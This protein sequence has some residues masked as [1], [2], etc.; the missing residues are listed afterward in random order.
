MKCPIYISIP[1]ALFF[2][3]AQLRRGV[4]HAT[5][6]VNALGF[7]RP[8]GT[9]ELHWFWNS[10]NTRGFYQVKQSLREQRAKSLDFKP[11]FTNIVQEAGTSMASGMSERQQGKQ[12][13]K[14]RWSAHLY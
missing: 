9:M 14:I 8:R 12:A 13:K 1:I 10:C 7:R 2:Y 5:P 6:N 11:P 3:P 4:L